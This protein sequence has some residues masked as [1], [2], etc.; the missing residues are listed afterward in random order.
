MPANSR[1]RL[2]RSHKV[3]PR[4]LRLLCLRLENFDHVAIVQLRAQRDMAAIDLCADG[5][6]AKV[7]VHRICEIHDG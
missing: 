3:H 7:R 2:A 1:A 6:V 5:L 4:L